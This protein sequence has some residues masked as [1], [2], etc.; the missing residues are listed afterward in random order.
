M[1]TAIQ[2]NE[3]LFDW[4]PNEIQLEIFDSV[5]S[6]SENWKL[7]WNKNALIYFYISI[8]TEERTKIF[9]ETYARGHL[10]FVQQTLL[11]D[12]KVYSSVRYT[13]ACHELSKDDYS[14]LSNNERG[15]IKSIKFRKLLT[16]AILTLDTY[17]VTL[18][19]RKILRE[20]VNIVSSQWGTNLKL[21]LI[22]KL[23]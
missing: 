8:P 20:A 9:I 18:S 22:S 17:Y 4:L 1:M 16:K 21:S 10:Y 2:K 6:P 13:T 7:N 3:L 15:V 14:R 11:H 12:K 5:I 19:S 23:S